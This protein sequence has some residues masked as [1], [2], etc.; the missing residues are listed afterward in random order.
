MAQDSPI[1]RTEWRL[2]LGKRRALVIVPAFN[3]AESIAWVIRD[4]KRYAPW[5][6]VVI[7]NDGSED[8]TSLVARHAGA[9]VLD[10]PVN[11]GIG[12]AVQ[13]GFRYAWE[14]GYHL[15]FQFDGDGQHRA[16]RLADLARPILA[17]EADLVIGSRFL[18]PRGM[19]ATGSRWIGIKFLA[20][21]ITRLIQQRITDPTSGFRVAGRRTIELFAAEYPQDYPEPESLVLVVRQGLRVREVPATMRRRRGGASSIGLWHGAHY[22]AKVTLAVLMDMVKAPVQLEG[23]E[24]GALKTQGS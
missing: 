14:H 6:D 12:G 4:L 7:V 2:D 17:E 3:E 11:L 24:P 16:R 8:D 22:M 18:K 23:T 5:A 20:N 15:A 9:K 13:T 21:I 10:L 1:H 19:T